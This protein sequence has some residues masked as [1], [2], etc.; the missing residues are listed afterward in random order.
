[1]QSFFE[2]K[3]AV[4]MTLLLMVTAAVAFG[5]NAYQTLTA[6]DSWNSPTTVSVSGTSEVM[7]VPDVAQFSFSVRAEG[8]DAATAQSESATRMNAALD[9]LAEQGIAEADITTSGY[10]LFPKYRFEQQPCRANFCP[11]G[12]QIQDGFE[13]TQTVTVKVRDT[14]QSGVLLT[15]VGEAG[16]TD[17][18]GLTF[19]IDDT[20]AL[21]AQART[22]A[23]ADAR[24]KAETLAANLGMQLGRIVS[25]YE[26]EPFM[27]S[28]YGM[29]GDM[30]MRA[31]MAVTPDIPVG[32][33]AITSQV[34]LIYELK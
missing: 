8:A 28:P 17:I 29:G 21:K 31:E 25:Y 23:I 27:P 14:A 22:E 16:A 4:P 15:G 34:S 12:E 6:R 26:E 1:M 9:F 19:T 18:S 2:H 13:V 33:S 5:A 32:E 24:A 20:D 11:P 10:N 3:Y 7:A 30:M